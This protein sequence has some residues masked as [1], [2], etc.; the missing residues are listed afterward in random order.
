[1][2]DPVELT[3]FFNV[4]GVLIGKGKRFVV[5]VSDN[6]PVD[7]EEFAEAVLRLMDWETT[8]TVKNTFSGMAKP[9]TTS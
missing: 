1:M 9:M 5:S 4:D 7:F 8:A 6:A 3:G 2:A